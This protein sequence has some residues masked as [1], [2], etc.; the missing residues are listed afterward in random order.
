M[1]RAEGYSWHSIAWGYF[2]TDVLGLPE[3]Q[4]TESFAMASN[5]VP[6]IIQIDGSFCEGG[7]QLLRNAVTLSAL[8]SKPISISNV[9][10]NRRPPGLR[11]QHEAGTF[12]LSLRLRFHQHPEKL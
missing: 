6:A 3:S 1:T 8:L 12:S 9:R 2:G 4:H 5:I 10:R 11:R 7:G